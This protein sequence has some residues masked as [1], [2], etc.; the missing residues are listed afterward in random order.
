MADYPE[1]AIKLFRHFIP[2]LEDY[3]LAVPAIRE[4][5]LW[6]LKHLSSIIQ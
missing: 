5:D 3:L 1:E 2:G 6:P 4:A